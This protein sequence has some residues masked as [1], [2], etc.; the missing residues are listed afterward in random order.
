M[1]VLVL[2]ASTRVSAQDVLASK[3]IRIVGVSLEI[4][5]AS[6]TVPK[7]QATGGSRGTWQLRSLKTVLGDLV[8][9]LTN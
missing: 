4:S 1:V 6:Q 9:S 3:D 2:C 8:A 7:N 5:P